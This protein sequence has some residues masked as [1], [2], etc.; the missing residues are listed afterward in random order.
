VAL[1]SQGGPYHDVNVCHLTDLLAERHDLN[2]GRSTLER[3]LKQR[4]L[5]QSA[6]PI[7]QARRHERR[8]RKPAE[9]MLV[10]M[11]GSS[12]DWLEGRGPRLCLVG[13]VDDATSKALYLRFHESES[14]QAYLLLLRTTAIEYGLPMSVYH[15]KHTILR[16]PA[17][18]TIDD[19][20]AGRMPMSQVQRVLFEL[21]VESIAAQSPQAKGRI[22]RVW[23]TL[24]D[25]LLKEMRLAMRLA[26]VCTMEGANAFL[27]GFIARFNVRF[28]KEP[29]EAEPVW[30]PLPEGLDVAYYF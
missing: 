6:R 1:A 26:G 10:Q 18:A 19:E 24:Q 30:V 8:E 2:I 16:S 9:G 29:R 13:S 22:E 11:D 15:D 5:R 27:P 20:L 7:Q 3:L 28:G 25:R 21:G 23:Q 14:Q 12:H 4:G 17:K